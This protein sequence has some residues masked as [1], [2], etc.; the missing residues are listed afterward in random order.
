MPADDAVS[1]IQG[2]RYP[3]GYIRRTDAAVSD[4]DRVAEK[5]LHPDALGMLIPGK[6]KH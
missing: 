5:L 4:H 2:D 1:P 3:T 6:D